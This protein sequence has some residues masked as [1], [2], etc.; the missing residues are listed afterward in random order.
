MK[1]QAIAYM[2]ACICDLNEPVTSKNMAACFFCLLSGTVTTVT[3]ECGTEGSGRDL[4]LDEVLYIPPQEAFSFIPNEPSV[5]LILSFHPC[6]LLEN[7]GCSWER[8]CASCGSP[9]KNS[10]PLA[11]AMASMA[12]LP[13]AR[14]ERMSGCLYAK[15]YEFLH[16]LELVYFQAE[17]STEAGSLSKKEATLNAVQEY[18][19]LHYQ[20]AVSLT[21]TAEAF[22]YAPTYLAGFLKKNLSMTFQ[23]YLTELRC[24]SA[25]LYLEL[26]DDPVLKIAADCGFPNLPAMNKAFVQNCKMTPEEIRG[27]RPK[28]FT[29]S[30]DQRLKRI[31]PQSRKLKYLM[32]FA[33]QQQE[34]PL[35]SKD[36]PALKVSCS[37]KD[38]SPLGLHWNELV[39][40]GSVA[41]FELPAFRKQIG[42]LQKE[43]H[44][45]YGRFLGLP[46]LVR[47]HTIDGRSIYDY[48]R[49]FQVIDYLN[50]I[51]LL[52]WIE[53]GRKPLNLDRFDKRTATGYEVLSRNSAYGDR[54]ENMLPDLIRALINR[55]GFDK[56]SLWRF[57]LWQDIPMNASRETYLEYSLYFRKITEIIRHELPEALIGGPGFHMHQFGSDLE[58]ALSRYLDIA[59]APDFYTALYFPV[60]LDPN[61]QGFGADRDTAYCLI[62]DPADMTEKVRGLRRLL[63]RHGKAHIPL[64]VTEYNAYPFEGNHL[65]DSIYPALYMIG[66]TLRQ[67][68]YA[69]SCAWWLASDL[70]LDHQNPSLPFFGGSGLISGDGVPKPAFHA[71]AMLRELRP[72]RTAQDEHYIITRDEEGCFVILAY[73]ISQLSPHFVNVPSSPDLLFYPYLPYAK[74][75]PLEF[76]IRLEDIKPCM[77]TVT[78]TALSLSSGNIL[79]LWQELGYRKDLT[80]ED[81]EYIRCQSHPHRS[82]FIKKIGNN[83]SL[84]F[85]LRPNE[86]ILYRFVPYLQEEN[87]VL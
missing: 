53:L 51:G 64:Y 28:A 9:G 30:L 11:S 42:S 46:Y 74:Q 45:K 58:Q 44:F 31:T 43:F 65:N 73:Y 39:N 19:R 48:S 56:V 6:F 36:G 77:Y 3:A 69:R 24:R 27:Q 35:F 40:L 47:T 81:F 26:T 49:I 87:Y 21:D 71:L 76:H 63:D 57:E 70:S 38:G 22:G 1:K 67:Q 79:G 86:L 41:D 84:R 37:M 13:E 8:V 83:Y 52:P 29:F 59:Y 75:E 82:A 72:V 16:Q 7:L 20:E 61:G 62:P 60:R 12:I 4:P 85:T 5:L 18:M 23:A 14:P 78:R 68:E 80:E 25:R 34:M 2:D 55:Y 17:D 54:L 66:Q 15:A 32:K 50:S 10:V 33:G